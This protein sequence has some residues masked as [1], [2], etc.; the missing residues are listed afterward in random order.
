MLCSI[1]NVGWYPR[2]DIR[3]RS[4][5]MGKGGGAT[6]REGGGGEQVKFYP[7]TKG[8]GRKRFSNAEVGAQKFLSS[9]N[10]GF[11]HTERGGGAQFFLSCLDWWGGGAQKVSDLRF[12][13]C[14]APPP[15]LPRN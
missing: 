3:D 1:L 7:N 13:H 12:S 8:R 11:S 15:P 4:L 9:F 2:V 14:I 6:K 10:T 5:F